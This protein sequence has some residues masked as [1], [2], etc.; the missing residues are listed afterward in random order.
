MPSCMKTNNKNNNLE[1]NITGAISAI[2]TSFSI[3]EDNWS[4]ITCNSG[5]EYKHKNQ[6][7]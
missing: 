3:T 2:E 7:K 1:N 6:Q 5:N 4:H